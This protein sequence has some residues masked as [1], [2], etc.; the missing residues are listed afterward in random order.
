[1][2]RLITSSITDDAQLPILK[3]TLDFLQDQEKENIKSCVYAMNNSSA[4]S[5]PIILW[6][7]AGTI[8]TVTVS[9]D[10]LTVTVGAIQYLGEIYQISAQSIT[11]TG[12]NVFTLL[13]DTT[14]FQAGEPTLY[15]DGA[16]SVNTNQD[17]KIKLGQ[18]LTGT[19]ICDWDNVIFYNLTLEDTS[20]SGSGDIVLNWGASTGYS[21]TSV[22]FNFRKQGSRVFIDGLLVIVPSSTTPNIQFNIKNVVRDTVYQSA[23]GYYPFTIYNFTDNVFNAGYLEQFVSEILF[24]KPTTYIIGKTY[25]LFFNISFEV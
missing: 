11:K 14:I 2:K 22:S 5:V 21:R 16:T 3:R 7:C 10:T 4:D 8:S 19:G 9:N 6:G 12:A 25:D 23:T 17:A 20:T 24:T 1:M 18:G 15:T 13:L